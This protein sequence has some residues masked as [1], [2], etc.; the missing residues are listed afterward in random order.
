MVL[1]AYLRALPGVRDLIVTVICG[2][3]TRKLGAS[4][5]APEPHDFAVRS[6]HRSSGDVL[7]SI[8]TRLAFVTTRNAP[9]IEAG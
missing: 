4:P 1:T 7:A 3:I 2:I 8:A 6:Q 9:R 5:G